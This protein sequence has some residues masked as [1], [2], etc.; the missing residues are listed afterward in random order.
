M[1]A[2]ISNG[3]STYNLDTTGWT[4]PLNSPLPLLM[5]ANFGDPASSTDY[6][7]SAILGLQG[8][9]TN[10]QRRAIQA[11]N[12]SGI[13]TIGSIA[14]VLVEANDQNQFTNYDPSTNHRIVEDP[15]NVANSTT[16]DGNTYWAT[17]VVHPGTVA[18]G[19]PTSGGSCTAGTHTWVITYISA[20]GESTPSA[21]ASNVVTCVSSTGQTVPLTLPLGPTSPATTS[22]NIYRTVAGNTGS[23]LLVATVSDNS[24]TTYSDTTADGALGVAAPTVNK[25]QP[26][27]LIINSPNTGEVSGS[28]GVIICDGAANPANNSSCA[29][30]HP[31]YFQADATHN[32]VTVVYRAVASNDTIC[33]KG[34]DA[35]FFGTGILGSAVVTGGSGGTL[36]NSGTWSTTGGAGTSAVGSFTASGGTLATVT[37]TN[38]GSGYT[39]NPTFVPS[40]GSLGTGTVA[41]SSATNA[42]DATSVTNYATA[43]S[44]GA[45]YLNVTGKELRILTKMQAWNSSA[46][47]NTTEA[48]FLGTGAIYESAAITNSNNLTAI[49][50]SDEWT[51]TQVCYVSVIA[52][53]ITVGIGSGSTA[54]VLERNILKQPVGLNSSL[55]N[56]QSITPAVMFSSNTA[57]NCRQLLSMT[58][59]AY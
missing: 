40:S 54:L 1:T 7:G 31:P 19:V 27:V 3:G 33:G 49:G 52:D 5:L 32:P 23:F 38:G 29:T 2:T 30:G 13:G 51:V 44:M 18:A 10:I 26:A 15:I 46:A 25:F 48:L 50:F 17:G 24:T 39:S 57:G 55:V 22:R 14:W 43:F 16:N 28:S 34:A 6:S 59:E 56:A 42:S 47:T 4:S 35:A 8:G 45:G 20:S 11:Y 53:Q 37:I 12:P 41:F 36:P 21:T 58:V 9:V